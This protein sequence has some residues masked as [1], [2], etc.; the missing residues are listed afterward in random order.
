[1][2]F[3]EAMYSYIPRIAAVHTN[4]H[5]TFGNMPPLLQLHAPSTLHATV[6]FQLRALYANW[7]YNILFRVV[8]L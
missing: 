8:Q 1:M 3:L 2:V 6:N 7:R 4:A 5:T